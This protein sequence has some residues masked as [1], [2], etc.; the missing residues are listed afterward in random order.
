MAATQP[1]THDGAVKVRAFEAGDE[2]RVL[3][4]LHA[5][6]GTWP[7]DIQSVT[8]TEFFRWKHMDGAFGP[9]T[10]LV[11]EA[12]GGVVGFAAYMPWLFRAHGKVLATA[13]GV[14]FVVDPSVRRRGTSGAMR[15][16]FG[17]SSRVPLVWSNPNEKSRPSNVRAS[18]VQI[19][20]LP[21][22]MQPGGSPRE[23]L[24][25]A[26]GKG[27]KTPEQLHIEAQTTAE[28]LGDGLHGDL[29]L[30][31]ASEP[32]DRVA[33]AK[34]PDYLRWR[35]GRFDEYRAVHADAT[36]GEGIAIFRPRRH[37]PFWVLDVCELLVDRRDPRAIRH[38][39]RRVRGSAPADFIICSFSSRLRAL[40]CGFAQLPG[41][42]D[43]MTDT[44][45]ENLPFDPARRASWALSRGDLELL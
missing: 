17:L 7:R 23:T 36:K 20:R 38:V 5:A 12:D 28:L 45:Q 39:L 10:L 29:L 24:A 37:G 40:R 14:D 26:R 4:L 34:D 8:P 19:C 18:G 33:T 30:S 22:F 16:A 32:N 1:T 13:R 43:L 27:S 2:P 41:G 35:Y 42:T 21:R 3:E 31:H 9:S 15:A 25:R 44:L 11:A 6:F